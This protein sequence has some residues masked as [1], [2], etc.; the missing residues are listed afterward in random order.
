G[1]PHRV[2]VPDTLSNT[3]HVIDPRT[4][5]VVSRFA[6]DALPHHVTPSWDMTRLYVNNTVGNTLT[7]IDARTGRPTRTIPV[8]DPYNLYF[9]PDGKRAIVVAERER[10][11]DFRH[12]KTWKL[13]A[14]VHVPWPGVDHLDFT[15]DGRY[16]VASAEFSGVV[17]KVDVVRMRLV[18][19][20][21]VGSLPIDVRLSADGK[22]FYVADQ[23][24]HGVHVLD[25]GTLRK[26]SFIPTAR[27]AH[28]L[29]VS[30]DGKYLY[31]SNRLAGSIH[32]IA[33]ATRKVVARWNV[34]GSPDM[35]QVSP[36]GTQLWTADRFSN[37]VTVVDAR[38]GVVL[39]RITV[40]SQPHGLAY[41]PQPGR[42]SVGHN[43]VYR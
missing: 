36:D 11:L 29:C 17:V 35:L 2:Y 39:K 19:H 43:G 7:E 16:L 40:G 28:G 15:A 21:V 12:P 22:V 9:T 33:F 5:R 3:V 20:A 32:V 25:A 24:V 1:T 10:R 38:R 30:R 6:V 13:I 26:L 34:G 23:G 37:T 42:Y 41:F 8:H 14:S 4:F 31:V 27:G 18:R